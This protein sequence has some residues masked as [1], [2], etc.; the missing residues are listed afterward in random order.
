MSLC[1]LKALK[2]IE[3]AHSCPLTRRD[4]RSG[5]GTAE[6]LFVNKR[7]ARIKFYEIFHLN[8]VEKLF[9]GEQNDACIFCTPDAVMVSAEQ[10]RLKRGRGAFCRD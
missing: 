2:Y 9:V 1:S 6:L 4:V 10:G 8:R 7:E 3:Q 5:E